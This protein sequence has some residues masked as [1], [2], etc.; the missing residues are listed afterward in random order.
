MFL[1]VW[2]Q[3]NLL[4][5]DGQVLVRNHAAKTESCV[6]PSSRC[7]TPFSSTFQAAQGALASTWFV[8]CSLVARSPSERCTMVEEA[9]L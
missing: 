7:S 5:C 6:S 9:A 4:A 2:N 1:S 8:G 3:D